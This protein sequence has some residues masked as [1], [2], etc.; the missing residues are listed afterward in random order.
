MLLGVEA[1]SVSGLVIFV[2]FHHF[3]DALIS[4]SRKATR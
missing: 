4:R 1:A 2:W 3:K